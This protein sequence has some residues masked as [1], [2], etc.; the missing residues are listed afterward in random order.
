MAEMEMGMIFDGRP[1]DPTVLDEA[2]RKKVAEYIQKRVGGMRCPDHDEAPTIICKGDR[3][4]RLSFDVE[5]CCQ[6]IIYLV[7]EKLEE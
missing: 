6:K 3:L 5:G 7:R 4:D 1:G 2:T